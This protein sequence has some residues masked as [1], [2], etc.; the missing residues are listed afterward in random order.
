MI[1]DLRKSLKTV[2]IYWEEYNK[3]DEGYLNEENDSIKR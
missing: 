2:Y 1:L 3:N